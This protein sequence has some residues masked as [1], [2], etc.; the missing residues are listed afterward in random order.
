MNVPVVH[1][2][3]QVTIVNM[4]LSPL[5]RGIPNQM[6]RIFNL[7][8]MSTVVGI[9]CGSLALRDN[10]RSRSRRLS[11]AHRRKPGAAGAATPTTK[12]SWV[13]SGPTVPG[14]TE[15]GRCQMRRT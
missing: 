15:A 14:A 11:Q 3:L 9:L 12:P 6:R 8:V 10:S 2:Q 5:Q 1:V 13:P 7:A 4:L